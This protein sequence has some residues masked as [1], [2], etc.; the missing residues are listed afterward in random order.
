[1]SSKAEVLAKVNPTTTYIGSRVKELINEV[2]C[3]DAPI[4]PSIL[5]KGDVIRVRIQADGSGKPRPSC[6]I[7][8]CKDYVVSIPLTTCNDVNALCETSGSRFFKEGWFCNIYVVTPIEKAVFI[9]TYGNMKSINNA[10][11]ELR[12]FIVKSV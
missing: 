10:I 9:G 3:E 8:V 12:L 1:M 6:V 2:T 11:K 4:Q 7:K 5:K